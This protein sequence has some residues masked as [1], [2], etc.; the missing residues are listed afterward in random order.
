MNSSYRVYRGGGWL[1]VVARYLAARA[2]RR[3]APPAHGSSLG[4][5]CVRLKNA[6]SYRVGRGGSWS[7]NAARCRA[8]I[9]D[10]FDPGYRGNSG[11]L[12]LRCVKEAHNAETGSSMS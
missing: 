11:Y 9:R 3:N 12:G 4:F 2:R 1:D 10:N 7:S 6:G 8:A 5:R